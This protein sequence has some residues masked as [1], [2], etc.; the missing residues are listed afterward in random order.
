VIFSG[1]YNQGGLFVK[2][3]N[4]LGW[5]A[6]VLTLSG[7]ATVQFINIAGADAA[8]GAY[9]MSPFF[10]DNPKPSIQKFVGDYSA[11]YGAANAAVVSEWAASTYDCVYLMAQALG[12][13]NAGKLSGKALIDWIK[14]NGKID[15]ILTMV[16]GFSENGDNPNASDVFLQVRN[17]K[18]AAY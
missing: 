8:E 12:D 3:K 14:K 13:P 7:C 5:D 4:S 10:P 9:S 15:G 2:Q 11:L 18:F 1:E 6:Q 16:N 17:G